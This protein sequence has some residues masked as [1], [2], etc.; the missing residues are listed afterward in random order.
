M[1]L[2]C[3]GPWAARPAGASRARARWH[4]VCGD[5]K[6][7]GCFDKLEAKQK[8]EKPD[9]ICTTT[10]D[11]N[12]VEA[13]VDAQ[14]NTLLATRESSS[15]TNTCLN[16]GILNADCSCT[17]PSGYESVNGGCFRI[18]PDGGFD[19]LRRGAR[20]LRRRGR[21]RDDA[22]QAGRRPGRSASGRPGSGGSLT[23]W[24]LGPPRGRQQQP[25]ARTAVKRCAAHSRPPRAQC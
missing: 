24:R 25:G 9:S 18:A 2:P 8:P 5:T 12:Q 11:T 3:S 15:C 14:V 13:Q 4:R 17:C 1:T 20:R 22:P 21:A 7:H 6:G 10:G 23:A 19:W 16:G